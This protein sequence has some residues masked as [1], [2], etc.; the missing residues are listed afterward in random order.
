MEP[1]PGKDK[2]K[3]LQLDVGSGG[4]PVA[5]VTSA[6]N[7]SAGAKVV[8]ALPGATVPIEG[9]EVVVKAA[10]VGGV[11]SSGM[12]CDAPM[13]KWTGGGA[14]NAALLPDSHVVGTAPPESRPRLK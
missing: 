10:T 2:L 1:V 4:G 9:E 6:P 12:L 5:V 13:L 8:V 3:L 11:K 14:G 7:V